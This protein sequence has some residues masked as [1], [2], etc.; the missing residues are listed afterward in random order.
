MKSF[1]PALAALGCMLATPALAA[2]GLDGASM[3]LLWAVPFAGMLL[4]IALGPLLAPKFWHHH[5]GKVAALWAGLTIVPLV[6]F[7]G[8]AP[9]SHVLFHTA[10]AEYVPFILMLFALFTAAGGLVLR[11]NLHGSP[12]LN[13][14]LL[15]VATL[16]A[17]VIGTTGAAMVFIR[18][19]LRAN[20]NR[21]HNVH[22]VIFFIFLVANIG[23]SLTPIGDPPLFLG[24]LRGVD[25][26]WTLTHLWPE[27][28]FASGVL[29]A[30]FF[31]VDL[32]LYRREGVVRPDPTPDSPLHV[33][34]LVNLGLI[35]V[36]IAA[37]AISGAWKP[38]IGVEILGT[39]LELQN[40]LREATM[41]LVGVASVV[42]TKSAEREHNGFE[43]GPIIEVAQI[44]AAIFVTIIPVMAM[45]HAGASGAFAPLVALVTGPNGA[46][47]N[48]AYFWLTGLLSSFLD[49]APT[50]LV[51]FEL[52]GG[53]A[54][55]LMGEMA[56]TLAAISLGAVYMGAN[57][58][59]GNAPNFMVYAIAR[60]GGVKM[61]SFFGYMLWSGGILVP[62]FV[63]VS[64]LFL[65]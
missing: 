39:R 11:G 10:A 13:V 43:W 62:L 3:S 56:S 49:N 32:T 58:Y 26:T 28:L 38:G 8:A 31:A 60:R 4:S 37:I 35:F 15:A 18:P 41:I 24:F 55:R 57:T 51:F 54:H 20:D 21:V 36:A 30:I 65:R 40:L 14:G 63:V 34:G 2:E 5:D 42:L 53:E 33:T 46:P 25:F 29:L 23:G 59:I 6:G 17:S 48:I 50:Y 9:T 12:V 45:L 1:I 7:M 44:F 61:P 27:T 64:I 19:L 22:V 16:M 52:A 47:N